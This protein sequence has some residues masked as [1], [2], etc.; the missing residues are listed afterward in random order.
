[1]LIIGISHVAVP[2]HDLSRIL[3]KNSE[4]VRIHTLTPAS[5]ASIM[6]LH[7]SGLNMLSS[8]FVVKV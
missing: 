3:S 7:Y 6:N 5:D 4:S 2:T 8:Y 1:M